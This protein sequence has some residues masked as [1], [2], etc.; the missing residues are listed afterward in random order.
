MTLPDPLT[1]PDCD[2]RNFPYMPLFVERIVN[3]ETV[4]GD[5]SAAQAALLLWCRAWH[6]KPAASVPDDDVALARMAGY[7]RDVRKWRRVR[8]KGALRGFVLC[9]DGRLYHPLVAEAALNA[10]GDKQGQGRRTFAAR[11]ALKE[12]R[13]LKAAAGAGQPVDIADDHSSVTEV[14]TE[15]VTGSNREGDLSTD[16]LR[17]S[18]PGAPGGGVDAPQPSL[19]GVAPPRPA[20]LDR[21]ALFRDGLDTLRR[22]TGLTEAR[23]RPLLGQ[24]LKLA[25][26]DAPGL[27]AVLRR[28]EEVRPA[29]AVSWLRRAAE[30]VGRGASQPAEGGADTDGLGI[31]RWL[32]RQQTEL[33]TVAGKRVACIA[34][35]HPP[36][37][38]EAITAAIAD[39]DATMVAQPN[40]DALAG[41]CRDNLPADQDAFFS[42]IRRVARG[43][44][45]P[46]R[47]MG[48][49]DAALREARR[50]AA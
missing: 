19:P 22:L 3:S 42:T 20:H 49:F 21:V 14:A 25:R 1:P 2:L 23:G 4:N 11:E 5:P 48:V 8:E 6:E 27:H 9:S 29:E 10:W 12:K 40:W 28:A 47:S 35:W 33:G 41:W 17:T 39:A 32:A 16:V 36:D 46:V 34:G 44:R 18:A 7:G 15:V 50:P 13:R 24:M 30:A 31:D 37:L 38:A 26:D 43:L 45:E